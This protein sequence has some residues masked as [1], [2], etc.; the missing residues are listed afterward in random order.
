MRGTR[1]EQLA[2]WRGCSRSS[3]QGLLCNVANGSYKWSIELVV[4]GRKVLAG[5]DGHVAWRYTPWLGSHA[6]KGGVRPL[7]RVL[8]V[9]I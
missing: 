2:S 8:Q 4:D 5:S 6:A 9:R 7:R 3:S 1:F